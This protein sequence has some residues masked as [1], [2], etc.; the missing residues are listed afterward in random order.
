MP[1]GSEPQNVT[2]TVPLVVG[3]V[4]E[5]TTVPSETWPWGSATWTSSRQ[6]GCPG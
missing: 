4:A 5:L 1:A 6:S 2:V 3:L